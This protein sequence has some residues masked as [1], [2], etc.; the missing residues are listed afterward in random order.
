MKIMKKTLP[1]FIFLGIGVFLILGLFFKISPFQIWQSILRFDLREFVVLL[2]LTFVAILIA[3]WRGKLILKSQGEDIKFWNLFF[4]G[5][6]GVAFSYLTPLVYVGGEGVK[7][8]LLNKQFNITWPKVAVYLTIDKLFEMTASFLVISAAVIAFVHRLGFPG[9]TKVMLTV[10]GLTGVIFVLFAIFYLVLFQKKRVFTKI[11]QT[12][13]LDKTK[14]GRGLIKAEGD[15][16]EFFDANS[17]YMWKAWFLSLL[18]QIFQVS[19][20]ILILFYLGKGLHF[21]ASLM[22]LGGLYLGYSLPIPGALGVQEAFQ[23]ILFAIFGWGAEQG[24]AVSFI[25]RGIDMFTVT[26]GVMVLFRYGIKFMARTT[27]ELIEKA[28]WGTRSN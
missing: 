11:L 28:K 24:L 10:V 5:T 18:R 2:T 27:L 20:H 26:V 6:A 12:I 13:R 16:L 4:V 25:L 1:G 22:S 7:G 21:S 9:L 3:V 14:V 8:Y 15:I 23:S 19:R 17:S